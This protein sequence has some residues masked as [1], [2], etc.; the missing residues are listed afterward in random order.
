MRLIG[1]KPLN[2]NK[3]TPKEKAL[4]LFNKYY[5]YDI[6]I[7]GT[8]SEFE[9]RG[10]SLYDA[11]KLALIAVDEIMNQCFD[12]RDIDLQAS[13]DYWLEVKSELEKL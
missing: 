13:Y 9:E 7:I 2:Q 11:K 5:Q 10:I 4:D 8:E 3:M 1:T 12:Y 6:T